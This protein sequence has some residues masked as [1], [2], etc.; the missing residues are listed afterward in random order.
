MMTRNLVMQV[1]A[2]SLAQRDSAALESWALRLPA[3]EKRDAALSAVVR[4]LGA[5]PPNATL[6][7]AFT[8]DRA[9]QGA[10]MTTVVATAQTD[11][12]A[13]R[14]LIDTHITDSRMREQ[15]E[16]VV[17]SI[18]RGDPAFP[19]GMPNMPAGVM[20]GGA[21]QFI[22]T[23]RD[24]AVPPGAVR[25]GPVGQ[26]V[27]LIGPNGQPMTIHSPVTGQMVVPGSA[28]EPPPAGAPRI[29]PA[30]PVVI[31]AESD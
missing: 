31:E 4:A 7:N 18:A 11:V 1:T 29:V 10:L 27:T 24:S 13:A 19:A 21:P 9:R 26:T 28:V 14:R 30:L 3:G 16:Q 20:R 8:D 15:A 23:V 22:E 5:A 25:L 6:L 2:A 12:A 17:D